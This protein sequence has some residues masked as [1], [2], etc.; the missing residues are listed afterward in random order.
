[1]ESNLQR[2]EN[3][4]NYL[5]KFRDNVISSDILHS[6]NNNVLNSINYYNLKLFLWNNS[7]LDYFYRIKYNIDTIDEIN[8]KFED[9][10]GNISFQSDDA[11]F[12]KNIETSKILISKNTCYIFDKNN[13]FVV[14]GINN[15]FNTDEVIDYIVTNEN[16]NQYLKN[17]LLKYTYIEID[18][19]GI[20]YFPKIENADW[21]ENTTQYIEEQFN[22]NF[23]LNNILNFAESKLL[24]DKKWNGSEWVY[25][26]DKYKLIQNN[27]IDEKRDAII[28]QGCPFTYNDNSYKLDMRNYQ[29]MINWLS[30]LTTCQNFIIN[31][32]NDISISI[33]TY[34]NVTLNINVVELSNIILNAQAYISQIYGTAWYYK[35]QLKQLN[36]KEEIDE[37]MKQVEY[38]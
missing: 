28:S 32:Q 31:G 19:N 35:D 15:K 36:S 4:W 7:L 33:R 20:S 24:V 14:G 29:D 26:I 9:I 3:F 2:I 23:S 30:V 38:K 25:D 12:E 17:Q 5:I 8:I 27:I 18:E 34:E 10:I 1:M 13:R 16:E 22:A 21:N 11:L 37:F 6:V